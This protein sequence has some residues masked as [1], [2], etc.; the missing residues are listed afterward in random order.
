MSYSNLYLQSNKKIPTFV[1]LL[2][3][4][5]SFIFFFKLFSN[6]SIPT[7]ASSNE[8]RRIEIANLT[9]NQA[10][11]YWHTEKKETGWLIYGLKNS[12]LSSFAY[13]DRDIESK[14][15][16]Y[17]YHL[18]T[19]KNLIPETS[20]QFKLISN[21]KILS[22]ASVFTFITPKISKF[23]SNVSPAYGKLIQQNGE[24]VSDS[25]VMLE[26]KKSIPLIGLV[27]QS[28]EW[29]VPLF[30]LYQKD[31]LQQKQFKQN[32]TVTI[33]FLSES[34][35]NSFVEASV[36]SISPLPQTIVL[37]STY[38]FLD[39]ESVLGIQDFVHNKTGKSLQIIYP[40]ENSL[41]PGFSPLIKGVSKPNTDIFVTI[42]GNNR[43]YASKTKSNS[44]GLWD[45]HIKERML[46]GKYVISAESKSNDQIQETD[47]K[48]FLIIANEGNDARVLG[49][50][51]SAP[52]ITQ[53][54]TPTQEVPT[55][56]RMII[57]TS[58]STASQSAQPIPG[59]FD[60][61]PLVGGISFLILGVGVLLA[62]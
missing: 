16:E 46:I 3:I 6:S 58:S 14:K 30:A 4:A 22:T 5:T 40:K 18:V 32:D 23:S 25:I 41:I 48:T 8:L 12:S 13:D 34:G 19:L 26:F 29:L 27:K 53:Q 20:Y 31:S 28:G 52:T 1:V 45:I 55:P 2:I 61:I 62:F 36:K 11:I 33:S 43:T 50:A 42:Q 56:T 9:S 38:S 49:V 7:K 37:G 21:N 24:P 51:S 60:I 10:T 54:L 15:S 17:H 35:I 57:P 59:I 47:N 39:K 44:Q